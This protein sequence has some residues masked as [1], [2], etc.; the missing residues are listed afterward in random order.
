M[1]RLIKANLAIEVYDCLTLRVIQVPK[2]F[3]THNPS[4]LCILFTKVSN[5]F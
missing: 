5:P 4:Q 2:S 3:T 1:V